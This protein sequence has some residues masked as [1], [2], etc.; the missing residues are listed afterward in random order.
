HGLQ[1]RSDV[2]AI[3]EYIIAFED[4]VAEVDADAQL[5][6]LSPLDVRVVPGHGR[7]NLDRAADRVDYAWEFDQD[8]VAGRLEDPPT[9]TRDRGVERIA[10][11]AATPGERAFLILSH[12]PA[13]SHD[14]GGEYRGH[15]SIDSLGGHGQS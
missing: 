1:A 15:S 11:S 5:E 8:A 10:A 2:H 4:H 13:V 6:L 7:L 14:V 12:Q 9:T 3:A